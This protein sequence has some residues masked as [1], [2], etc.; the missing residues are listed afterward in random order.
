MHRSLILTVVAGALAV[1][2][3]AQATDTPSSGDR[4]NAAQECRFERGASAATREAFAAK[5][6]NFGACVST[7]ARDEAREGGRRRRGAAK[8][9]KA[10]RGTTA[11][12][13]AAFEQKYGTNKN[14]KNAY[15]KCVSQAAKAAEDKADDADHDHAAARK[16]AAKRCVPERGTSAA[17]RAAFAAKYGTDK[18]KRNAFGKWSPS[19]PRR[20]LTIER[21][22][23]ALG[24]PS[25]HGGF[26]PRKVSASRD[27]A[28]LRRRVTRRGR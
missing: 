13:R 21:K 28:G 12:S 16:R 11:A 26:P 27:G 8:A 6:R 3:A 5:Y 20:W 25:L 9:C 1:P 18:N 2:A 22:R 4:V 24:P 17:S 19:S 10:E 23:A 14:K 15:G 7:R